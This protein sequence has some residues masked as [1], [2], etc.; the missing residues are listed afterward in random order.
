MRLSVDID[1]VGVGAVVVD[2]RF[3]A[4]F[5]LFLATMVST[6]VSEGRLSSGDPSA[7]VGS[8]EYDGVV[9]EGDDPSACP[10]DAAAVAADGVRRRWRHW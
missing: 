7:V 9:L 6:S 3:P 8:V 2:V 4:V 1:E 5:A 10:E